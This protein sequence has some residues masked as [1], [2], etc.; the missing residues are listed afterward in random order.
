MTY[1]MPFVP[2][3][4]IVLVFRSIRAEVSKDPMLLYG[5]LFFASNPSMRLISFIE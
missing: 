1:S 4:T 3:V 5:L 2:A